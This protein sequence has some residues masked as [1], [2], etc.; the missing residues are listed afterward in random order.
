M[1][2]S[3]RSTADESTLW[4]LAASATYLA[5]FSASH[6]SCLATP[7]LTAS[8]SGPEMSSDEWFGPVECCQARWR[9]QPRK[10]PLLAMLSSSAC[11]SIAS[12]DER[13]AD[14]GI[15][16]ARWTSVKYHM[17]RWHPLPSPSVPAMGV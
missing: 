14:E 13:S 15:V 7:S 6:F 17:L 10:H 16:H 12:K 5:V 3:C 11:T 1:A 2:D 4:T 9:R 8:G